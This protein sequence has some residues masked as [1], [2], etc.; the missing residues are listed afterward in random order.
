VIEALSINIDSVHFWCDSTIALSWIARNLSKWSTFTNRVAEIQKLTTNGQWHHIHSESNPADV[1]SRGMDPDEIRVHDLWWN[2]PSFLQ[3][4]YMEIIR[5]L[6]QL[7]RI[8]KIPEVKKQAIALVMTPAGD[9]TIINKFSSLVRLRRTVAYCLRFVQ[10][11]RQGAMDSDSKITGPLQAEEL[12]RSMRILLAIAQRE[13]FSEEIQQLSHGRKLSPKSKLLP[14]HPFLDTNGLLRVGGR[15]QKAQLDYSQR[16]PIILP[17]GHHLTHLII[18]EEHLKNL[19]AGVQSL[20][21]IIRTRYWPITGKNI[22]RKVLHKCIVCRRTPV[23]QLMG[24]LPASRVLPLPPFSTSGIDYAG[25]FNIKISR[26]KSG[27]A[28]LCVFVCFVTKAVHL[29]IVSD[30]STPAFLNALKRFIAK[31]GTCLNIYSD[32]GTNF[33]GANNALKEMYLMVNSSNAEIHNYLSEQAIKWHFLPPQSP[34]ME[35]LWESAVKVVKNRLTKIVGSTSLIFEELTTVVTQIEAV[36]NSRP[37]TP[38]SSDPADLSVLT[39]GHFLIGRPLVAICEP[40][41]TDV[42]VNR[43]NRYQLLEQIRQNFW[44]RWSVEYLTTT[45]AKK[46][47]EKGTR[48]DSQGHYGHTA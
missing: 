29:E 48:F 19:H 21:A 8:K 33:V 28:Y 43:L 20:L 39:P 2:G 44:K 35:G 40:D 14:L 10:N 25:P 3:E 30:L 7:P 32:N 11:S 6:P 47:V 15:L 42:S 4:D 38:M 9:V 17:K 34:H 31:R 22:I 5:N 37:L 27:K 18:M 1:L 16:H 13:K 46:Q 41:I 26:N 45:T 24:S 12:E 23:E 36:L